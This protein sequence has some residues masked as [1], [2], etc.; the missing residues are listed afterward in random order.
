MR[1]AAERAAAEINGKGG[2]KGRPLR[3]R[4]ADDSGREDT[5]VRVDEDLYREPDLVAVV[6]HLTSGTTIAAARVYGGGASPV[7]MI[8]PSASSP[9]LSGINPYFFRVGP[10]D[11]SHGPEPARF[12]RP[13]LGA[14]A[15][16]LPSL[17]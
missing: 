7:P 2:V 14:Q 6:G 8:S 9:D 16:G 15:A 10:T 12:A 17:N 11:L 4:V 5:A 1:Q 3:L 13:A